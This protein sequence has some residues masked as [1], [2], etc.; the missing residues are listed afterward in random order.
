V[1]P[2]LLALLFIAGLAWFGDLDIGWTYLAAIDVGSVSG[3]SIAIVAGYIAGLFLRGISRGPLAMMLDWIGVRV[4][5]AAHIDRVLLLGSLRPQRSMSEELDSTR[6]LAQTALAKHLELEPSTLSDWVRFYSAA[7]AALRESK[8]SSL[9]ST[10]QNKYTFHRSLAVAFTVLAWT[11]GVLAVVS[12]ARDRSDVALY[13]GWLAVSL[14][15]TSISRH[16]FKRNWL[17]WGDTVIVETLAA[18]SP[19]PKPKPA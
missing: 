1:L 13:V 11:A 16:Q 6:E 19:T 2:G 10:Y 15:G 7:K 3:F 17:L 14:L 4:S 5:G 8:S 9:I 12:I 18:F